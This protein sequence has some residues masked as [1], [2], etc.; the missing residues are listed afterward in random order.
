MQIPVK[1]L[2]K[3]LPVG[4]KISSNSATSIVTYI[5]MYNTRVVFTV[6]E[7]K[8]IINQHAQVNIIH[9]NLS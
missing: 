3:A 7:R 5:K 4:P 1:I 9:V 2:I 6:A 8:T